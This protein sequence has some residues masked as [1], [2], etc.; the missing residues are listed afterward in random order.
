M[1]DDEDLQNVAVV[2]TQHQTLERGLKLVGF[3]EKRIKSVRWKKNLSR[4]CTHYN[5]HP[6]IYAVLLTKLQTTNIKEARLE[7]NQ[8]V[9]VDRTIDYFFMAIHLLANYPE[10]EIAEGIFKICDRTW[11]TWVWS[12]V[13]K[14]HML[15]PE[16]IVWPKKWTNPE[17]PEDDSQTIFT[18]SV[19]GTHC[20]INEPTHEEFSENTQY[21]SHKFHKAGLDYEVAISIYTGNCVWVAGPYPAG[22]NDISVFRHRLKQK[23]LDS[24][25]SGVQHR[26]LGDKGYRGERDVLSVPSSHDTPEVRDFKSRALSRHETFNARLKT[27]DCLDDTFRHPDLEKHQWC[28]DAVSVIVQLQLENGFPLFKV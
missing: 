16:V 18:I 15:K 28:F 27:F 3:D 26:A 5:S 24:R 4:F 8:R 17:N 1:G 6:L 7:F 14:I 21:Y 23:I 19:D 25:Q 9:G 12:I 2:L 22:K 11:R 10:E 20:P 13:K